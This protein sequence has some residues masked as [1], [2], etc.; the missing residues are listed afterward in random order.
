MA[1]SGVFCGIATH[2]EAIVNEMRRF[3][4]EQG[5]ARDKFE[6]QML[7]GVRRDLQRR[8]KAEGFGVRVYVP[9]GTAW[10]PYFMRRLAERPANVLFL[11]KN[12]L[13]K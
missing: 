8:L 9:F 2:D 13:R 4:A 10:Y 7:Y 1:T 3:V 11:V 12:F 5:L 6:F